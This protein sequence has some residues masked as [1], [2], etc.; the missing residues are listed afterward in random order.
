MYFIQKT[1]ETS[2]RIMRKQIE[3]LT[4]GVTKFDICIEKWFMPSN[5]MFYNFEITLCCDLPR[6]YSFTCKVVGFAL[7]DP[8]W[9]QKRITDV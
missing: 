9:F 7:D 6:A 5:E 8:T 1:E 4:I 2:Y 3:R